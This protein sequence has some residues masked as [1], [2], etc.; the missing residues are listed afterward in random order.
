MPTEILVLLIAFQIKHFIADYPLQFPYMYENKGKSIGWIEPLF[1]HS[2]VHAFFTAMIVFTFTGSPELMMAAIVFDLTTH[3][4]IDRW[5]A[6]R[7]NGPD[8]YWFWH[9]LGID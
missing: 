3:F 9:N 8:N 4:I 7:P 2:S 6:T 1:I 5:K